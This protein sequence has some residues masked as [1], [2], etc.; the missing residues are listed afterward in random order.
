MENILDSVR[1]DELLKSPCAVSEISWA[2][3]C[4]SA[5]RDARLWA[6]SLQNFSQRCANIMLISVGPGIG[7]R[8]R[9]LSMRRLP[10]GNPD[11]ARFFRIA[12]AGNA[13]ARGV[14]NAA[15]ER[16]TSVHKHL[17]SQAQPFR[18]TLRE[19]ARHRRPALRRGVVD[20]PIGV[21]DVVPVPL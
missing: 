2:E 5:V 17:T 13:T 18:Q 3:T 9:Q 8:L 21:A 16:K 4:G 20:A 12:R 7:G 15:S 19:L 10:S 1:C 6:S 11:N 14:R